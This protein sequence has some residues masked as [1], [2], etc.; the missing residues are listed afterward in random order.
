MKGNTIRVSQVYRSHA[1]VKPKLGLYKYEAM[2]EL[3]EGLI[4]PF[5]SVVGS[6]EVSPSNNV[7]HK[8]ELLLC[9]NRCSCHHNSKFAKPSETWRLVLSFK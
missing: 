9:S 4:T 1:I 6:V 7:Q 5:H 3:V 2:K 8:T